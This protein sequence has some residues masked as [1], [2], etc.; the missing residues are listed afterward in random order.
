MS[1]GMPSVWL[2]DKS[3]RHMDGKVNGNKVNGKIPFD[4]FIVKS[5]KFLAQ[6]NLNF[7]NQENWRK[8]FKQKQQIE[9]LKHRGE[10]FIYIHDML[11]GIEFIECCTIT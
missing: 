3:P 4:K 5:K 6:K 2:G 7:P 10:F 8:K 9:V 1:C 11:R